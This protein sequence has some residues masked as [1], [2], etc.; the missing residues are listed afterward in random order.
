MK[1][2]R[3]VP[4]LGGNVEP[5]IP[6]ESNLHRALVMVARE[7]AKELAAG[8]AETQESTPTAAPA[9]VGKHPKA[10]KARVR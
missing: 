9:A 7:V 8:S 10:R 5:L 3:P 1:K 4:A 6:P 2:K